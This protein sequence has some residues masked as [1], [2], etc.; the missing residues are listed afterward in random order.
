MKQEIKYTK[1]LTTK[2]LLEVL[3][4][5][6]QTIQSAIAR[7]KLKVYSKIQGLNLYTMD[8]VFDWVSSRRRGGTPT[9][10][11]NLTKE[12]F[13]KRCSDLGIDYSEF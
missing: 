2:D 6:P 1:L 9:F 8:D 10:M 5:S 13:I 11:D 3:E 4:C 12:E 7:G